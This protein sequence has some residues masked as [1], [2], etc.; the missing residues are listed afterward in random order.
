MSSLPLRATNRC[1]PPYAKVMPAVWLDHIL[2]QLADTSG[3]DVFTLRAAVAVV[4]LG[5]TCG[6]VG[7]QV[8]GS[9][10]AFF[11]DAMAHT[12]F[13]GV[14][15]SLLLLVLLAGVRSDADAEPYLWLV[16]LGAA[17]SGVAAGL[18]IAAV[19]DR[20]GLTN[21][22]VI[23]VFFAL[24]VGLGAMLLPALGRVVR[25]YNP[26][27]FLFGGLSSV[28]AGDLLSLVGLVA[29]TVAVV[30]RRSNALSLASF[31]PSLARSRGLPVQRDGYLFIALLA[32]TV[33][34]AVGIL[35][36]L[37][38]NALLVVPAAAAANLGRNLRQ[39]FW[40]TLAGS[41]G[42]GLAGVFLSNALAV[43]LAG[44]TVRFGPSGLAVVVCVG[45]FFLT[46]FVAAVR[47]RPA[48]RAG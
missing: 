1:V 2:G 26:E 22:T 7:T 27:S 33:N 4:L 44:Q 19:R 28:G 45:W 46:M 43:T 32:V 15:V 3:V 20:T 39:V 47:G 21:D 40:L 14:A 34:L 18:G 42:C 9:R 23:G 16:P 30:W 37:L 8:V 12:A 10:M 31:N 5:I 41:V 24:A 6:L 29:L 48:G 17:G 25:R 35:G 11:S 36:A 13:A 38:I